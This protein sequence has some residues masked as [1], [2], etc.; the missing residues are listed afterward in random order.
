MTQLTDKEWFEAKRNAYGLGKTWR[1]IQRE[2]ASRRMR[3]DLFFLL[4][5]VGFIILL[6]L[7]G[8]VAR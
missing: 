2:K 7:V 1:Q 4:G 3:E 8:G 5:L 6:A